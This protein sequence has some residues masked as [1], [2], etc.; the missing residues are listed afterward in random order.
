MVRVTA[1][2][3]C[4]RQP[5]TDCLVDRVQAPKV[6][7]EGVP[8]GGPSGARQVGCRGELAKQGKQRVRSFIGELWCGDSRMSGHAPT[9]A[10][11]ATFRLR[12]S[13]RRLL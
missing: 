13:G 12:V 4:N 7:R 10:R 1:L 9:D 3:R 8:A 5:A 11:L 2:K 6:F